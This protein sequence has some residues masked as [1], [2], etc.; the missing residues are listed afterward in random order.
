ME[1][2]IFTAELNG[3]KFAPTN[4]Y[5]EIA[6]NV[7]TICTTPKYSVPLDREFGVD[8]SFLDKTQIKA[9]AMLQSEIIQAVRKY[10]PRCKIVKVIYKGNYNGLLDAEIRIAIEK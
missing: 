6:Q 8:M 10:E 9:A 1:I 2:S 5:E 3:V 4:I 7:K